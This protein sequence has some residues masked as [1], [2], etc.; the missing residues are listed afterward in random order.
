[1]ADETKNAEV[2]EIRKQFDDLKK[3]VTDMGRTL[4]SDIAEKVQITKKKIVDDSSEWVKEHP[5]QSVGIIAGVAA[6]VGFIL[7]LMAGRGR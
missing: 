1:M 6:S 3:D 2:K 4:K 7:G 5:A